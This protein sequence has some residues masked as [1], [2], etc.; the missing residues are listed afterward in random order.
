MASNGQR[1][2]IGGDTP[3]GSGRPIDLDIEGDNHNTETHDQGHREKDVNHECDTSKRTDQGK[4]YNEDNLQ[5]WRDRCLRRDEEVKALTN[6][7]YSDPGLFSF[8][9]CIRT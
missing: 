6:K 8:V 5:V 9:Y 7:L 2:N 3:I 4:Y 1:E